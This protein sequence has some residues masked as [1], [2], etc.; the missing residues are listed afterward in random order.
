MKMADAYGTLV[1]SKSSDGVVDAN[2]LARALNEARW[3][4]DGGEWAVT[5]SQQLLCFSNPKPQY[6]TLAP[7]IDY[8]SHCYDTTQQRSYSKPTAEMTE[9]D[10]DHFEDADYRDFTLEEIRDMAVPYIARGLSRLKTVSL[11]S[12]SEMELPRGHFDFRFKFSSLL[13]LVRCGLLCS[14]SS[15]LFINPTLNILQL[16]SPGS[17][18]FKAGQLSLLG[19]PVDRL[20]IHAQ[21]ACN[22]ADGHGG[23]RLFDHEISPT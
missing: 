8:I 1:F 23:R 15:F 6:P 20:L 10:W 17:C 21:E 22:F 3:N 7:E 19:E 16:E 18:H 5:T 12:A 9:S 13:R 2:G 11:R 14:C 4:N